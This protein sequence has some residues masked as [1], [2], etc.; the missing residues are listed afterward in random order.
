MASDSFLT[1]GN[2]TTARRWSPHRNQIP[3]LTKCKFQESDVSDSDRPDAKSQAG[4]DLG[5]RDL[6]PRNS[7]FELR[8]YCDVTMVKFEIYNHKQNKA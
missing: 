3:L 1:T 6:H 2:H 5:T 7:W 4:F 8:R